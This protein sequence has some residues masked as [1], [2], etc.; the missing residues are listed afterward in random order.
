MCFKKDE[1]LNISL[2]IEKVNQTLYQ[3]RESITL[4]SDVLT[5]LEELV[6]ILQR[7]EEEYKGLSNYKKAIK[8]FEV[9]RMLSD[10]NIC[11]M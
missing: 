11:T 6:E 1:S 7:S 3:M 9:F 4:T 5:N 8:L 10:A 2:A